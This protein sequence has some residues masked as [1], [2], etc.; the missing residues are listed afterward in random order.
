MSKERA[1]IALIGIGCRFPGGAH[2]PEATWRVLS[3]GFDPVREVP[4]DR[5]DGD[6]WYDPDPETPGKALTNQG[7]FLDDVAHFD[8]AR[9]GISP[10]EALQMDPQQRLL[11]EVAWEALEDAGH[12]PDQMVG[13]RTGVFVGMGDRAEASVVAMASRASLR[14][15]SGDGRSRG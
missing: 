8:A 12:A 3:S 14:L 6:A 9:F 10:R 15:A 5:W 13:T 1:R 7:A 4:P 2:G 11:L